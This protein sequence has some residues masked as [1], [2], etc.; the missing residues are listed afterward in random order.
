[1]ATSLP[2]DQTDRVT[3][4]LSAVAKSV[5]RRK[6]IARGDTWQKDWG[7]TLN[8][9]ILQVFDVMLN[10]HLEDTGPD[11][12]TVEMNYCSMV[13]LAGGITGVLS[14]RCETES[15]VRIA[16]LML[17]SPDEATD[18]TVQDALGEISNMIAGDFKAKIPGMDDG[19]ML[20]VPT[21]I[22]G[23]DYVVRSLANG[24]RLQA[25]YWL[26]GRP[27]SVTLELHS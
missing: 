27:L 9:A 6:D 13:G 15:G 2:S 24:N 21:V 19:C 4:E 17:G 1:M 12:S 10:T 7:G 8:E 11:P 5:S 16:T 3:I 26:S 25:V 20:S 23:K 18:A 22:N 14:V